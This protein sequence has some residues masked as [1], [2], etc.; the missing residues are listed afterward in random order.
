LEGG[1]HTLTKEL[2]ID[3]P[4]RLLEVAKL[5]MDNCRI[6]CGGA[7]ESV[8]AALQAFEGAPCAGQPWTAPCAVASGL[9]VEYGDDRPQDRPQSGVWVGAAAGVYLRRSIISCT[10]GPGVKIYRGELIAEDS[11]IAFS[12]RG[13][14]VVANGGK[15]HLLRNEIRG[16]VGDGVSSWN[17][18]Q[19]HIEHNRLHSNS[20][21]GVAIN[22]VAG[23]AIITDNNVFGNSKAAV[24][25]VT[26]Q[27]QQATLR[28]NTI[29]ENGGGVVGLRRPAPHRGQ[30]SQLLTPARMQS[31]T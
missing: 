7:A 3:M 2:T 17:N 28:D 11:T 27:A 21:S 23:S 19:I 24:F 9:N 20:G 14:N 6:T 25:F 12:R 16:A 10:M 8:E 4:L 30:Q 29:E 22:S 1:L 31:F 13:A 26:S 5:S 18:A 15:V